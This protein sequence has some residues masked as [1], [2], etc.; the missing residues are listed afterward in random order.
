MTLE[1][2]NAAAQSIRNLLDL[3]NE[4]RLRDL[5]LDALKTRLEHLKEQW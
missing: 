2:R 4:D 1:E 3:T 5:Q